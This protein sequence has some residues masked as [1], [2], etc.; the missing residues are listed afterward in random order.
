MSSVP[1][2]IDKYE[3]AER[4]GQG[5]VAEVW[6]AFDTQ[7]QRYVALKVL[8]ANLREDPEFVKRFQRE[9][10]LIASLHHP[11]IVQVHDFQ[12]FQS[13]NLAN[14]ASTSTAYMVMDYIEGQT[15][16]Q[17]I[18]ATSRK[19]SIPAPREIVNLFS[20]IGR[21]V[22]YAH[23]KGMIHRD[24]KPANIMLDKR[25]TLLNPMGEPILTDFGIA[26]LLSASATT[27]TGMQLSTPLYISPEQ[28][29]G[30]SGTER[31]DIYALGIILYELVTGVLPFH[32]NT[33]IEVMTQHI[34]TQPIA[35]SLINPHL[36]PA[37]VQ[38]VMR[39]LAKDPSARF[40][41]AG[42]MTAAIARACGLPVP[43]NSEQPSQSLDEENTPTIRITPL[44]SVSARPH[45][46]PMADVHDQPTHILKSP[47][48]EPPVRGTSSP[49]PVPEQEQSVGNAYPA[50]NPPAERVIGP[51]TP[52]SEQGTLVQGSP[53]VAALPPFHPRE[54]RKRFALIAAIV[55]GLLA[56]LVITGL[57]IPALMP[58]PAASINA[59]V[60]RAFYV[61]SG[62]L[63]PG[64]AQGIADQMQIDLQNVPAPQAG[65]RYYVWLLGD[66]VSVGS[67]EDLTGPPP[68]HP[69]L[70]LT[71]N[72][73]VQN[74]KVHY[75][76]P[77]D[78]QHNNLLSQT[79]RLLITEEN[80]NGTPSMPSRDRASWRYYSAIP[81]QPIPLDPTHLNAL[82][83]IR[84]LFFDESHLK[85]L[86]L[87]GGL[88]FWLFR[89]TEKVLEAAVSA[90]DDW[91]GEQTDDA[92]ISLMKNQFIR[93]LDYLDGSA[94]VHIDVSADTPLLAD[95]TI[96]RVALLTV[97]PLRQGGP[98]LAT[99]PPGYIDH[100]QLHV[101]QI[102]RATDISSDMRQRTAHIL[103]ALK[104]AG[105][106]LSRVHDDA[107][108]LYKLG[109][110]PAQ[111][112]QPEAGRLLDDMVTQITSAYIGQLDPVTDQVLPGVMQA[113]NDI[114]QLAT[115]VITKDVPQNV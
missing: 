54:R 84:H 83:H 8:H 14:S 100:T 16:G 71:N 66:N 104:N 36:P 63:K 11:N 27:Q 98:N 109:N 69:P 40:S 28:A 70:L 31:S 29:R 9:A 39:A 64:T 33:P 41:S 114:Q 48:S 93:I 57:V 52:L 81:Q 43:G 26:K 82:N 85:V 78:A 15:L 6:K 110:D 73:L 97:D 75:L 42:A 47:G 4:L 60:G 105:N 49:E 102:A 59:L 23:T 68:V 90:R 113:H 74:G 67:R 45:E 10:Q 20:S 108:K 101:G 5:G 111:L 95:P 94:N 34:Q 55:M 37:L 1:Q 87:P 65:K 62:Q 91:H 86:A 112:R 92:Q 115:L 7:L 30:A 107:V 103:D 17:Y 44:P 35:P 32:G 38:V 24:I 56:V 58:R 51:Q 21:A 12:V 13:T 72:L 61:S 46:V 53:A 19:G 79:S 22:D 2:R 18:Y 89:N 80:A 96:S 99:N 106:W 77:G 76:F 50:I 3:L 88:D 25:H